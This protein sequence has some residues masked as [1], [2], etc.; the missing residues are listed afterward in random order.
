[1]LPLASL[2]GCLLFVSAL[3]TMLGQGGGA[4]YTPLQVIFGYD[5]H[6]AA[7]N[8]LFL[9][10][11]S[12]LAATLV[13][14]K[15]KRVDWSLA[16]ALESA[17][18]SGAFLGGFFSYLVPAST[19]SWIFASVIVT[20]GIAML[21]QAP[22]SAG[23]PMRSPRRFLWKRRC[24]SHRYLINML[25]AL[26]LMFLAGLLSGMIGIGGGVL[27]VPIFVLLLGVPMGVAVGTSAFMVGL[28]ATS[29]FVGHAI[30]GNWDPFTSFV[31]A[32]VVFV[33]G[34][35]GARVSI[36]LDQFRLRRVCAV[37]LIFAAVFMACE[38][39]I[40]AEALMADPVH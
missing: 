13:F 15:A 20:A 8:S 40:F 21:R 27:K 9:I 32:A 7:S 30:T 35:L 6:T 34:R 1:M 18:A 17:A 2:A 19:L 39:L 16:W 14:R 37:F 10:M 28:T 12:S 25:H 31:L 3:F 33:G 11:V 29:G 24:G 23:K 38:A 4:F 26:P 22:V 5:F 36:N